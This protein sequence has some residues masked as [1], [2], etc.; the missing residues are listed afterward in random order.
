MIL[1]YRKMMNI[2]R[3]AGKHKLRKY[4][5]DTHCYYTTL[6]FMDFAKKE[7]IAY[8]ENVL[9]LV[10]KHDLVETIS[11]DLIYTVKNINDVTRE[12]WAQIEREAIKVN[13][14]YEPYSDENLKKRLS[15]EQHDLLKCCDYLEL[16]I[17]IREEMELGNKTE[18]MEEV[19]DNCL[20]LMLGKFESIDE[21]VKNNLFI[22]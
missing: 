16:W 3:L 12:C 14:D 13:R 21:F 7:S 17:F 8:D 10:L 9:D 1:N 20:R 4:S 6:F 5:L 22:K 18:G 2:D 15:K 19:Y 11:A